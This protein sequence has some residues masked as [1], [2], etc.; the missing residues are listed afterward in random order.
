MSVA[1]KR[2]Q[3]KAPKRRYVVA[4]KQVVAAKRRYPGF[5]VI[6]NAMMA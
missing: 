1:L 6:R 5:T 3:E 4:A 2:E